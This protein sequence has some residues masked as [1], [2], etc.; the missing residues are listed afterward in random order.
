MNFDQY[1][2]YPGELISQVASES[3]ANGQNDV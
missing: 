2:R 3:A 1:L